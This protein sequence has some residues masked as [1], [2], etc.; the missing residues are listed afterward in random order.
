MENQKPYGTVLIKASYI[1]DFLAEAAHSSLQEIAKGCGMTP[2]TTLKILDT[3][4]LIGYVEKQADK[5]Y[6]LGSKLV[7]YAN[8]DI[9]QT[10]LVEN[11]RPYL[12][13]LNDALDETIHLGILSNNEIVYVNKLEPKSQ[14]ILMSSKIGITRPLYSSA[15]GKAVLAEFSERDYQ[16]YLAVTKLMPYT[17]QTITNP[18]KLAE[19]LAEIKRIGVAFDDEEMEKDIFCTGAAIMKGSE[20]LG[21]FSVSIPKYRVTPEFKKQVVQQVLG[22]KNKLEKR[23]AHN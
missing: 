2:S 9:Q 19:E 4:V 18:L 8:H 10:T 13:Q 23:F 7:R 6:R 16:A 20:I 15:M 17:S 22:T 3:L 5:T 21:A 1:L 11:S 12:E 14:T